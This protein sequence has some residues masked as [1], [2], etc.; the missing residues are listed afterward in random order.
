M[1]VR[2]GSLSVIALAP[3]APASAVFGWSDALGS[4]GS[5]AKLWRGPGAGGGGGGGAAVVGWAPTRPGR[6][7]GGR[8]RA[9][10]DRV[11]TTAPGRVEGERCPASARHRPVV[12]IEANE[13]AAKVVLAV[14]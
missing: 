14:A 9:V 12:R 10:V 7:G 3:A 2:I 5:E 11:A 6:G 1:S 8:E 4:D 13:V